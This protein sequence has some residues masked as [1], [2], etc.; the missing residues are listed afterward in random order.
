[1]SGESTGLILIPVALAAAPVLAAGLVVA[2]AAALTKSA[3]NAGVRY[4]QEKAQIRRQIRETGLSDGIASSFNEVRNCTER[5]RSA[6]LEA[7]RA[8]LKEFEFQR[9]QLLKAGAD[10]ELFDRFSADLKGQAQ[11]TLKKVDEIQRRFY[12]Q[13]RSEIELSM[14]S[15]AAIVNDQYVKS[16]GQLQRLQQNTSHLEQYAGQIAASAIR[17]GEALIGLLRADYDGER[18]VPAQLAGLEAQLAAVR[19][20]YQGRQYEAAISAAKDLTLNTYESIFD[21]SLKRSEWEN[22]YKNAYVLS[23]EVKA[24]V[25]TQSVITRQVK[26][27]AEISAGQALPDGLIGLNVADYC[28]KREDGQSEFAAYAAEAEQIWAALHG[29]S[30]RELDKSQLEQMILRLNTVLYPGITRCVRQGL[31]NMTNAF[32]RAE[33]GEQV[34]DFFEDHNF[35]FVGHSYDELDDSPLHIAFE[36]GI[37]DEL[38][39]VTLAPE[40]VNGSVQ[41]RVLLEQLQGDAMDEERKEFFREGISSMVRG[42]TPGA[43]VSLRCN[44]ATKFRL[45]NDTRAIRKIQQ[46]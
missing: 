28:L 43:D 14:Q 15:L 21:A 19:R 5:Q 32:L 7:S 30:A 34:I 25:E 1:M 3:I 9:S 11:N 8:M 29:E 36:N 33:L 12:S 38:L 10:T 16:V 13:Y 27:A 41:T 2:G 46:N 6:S 35:S 45:S 17:D 31:S 37:T 18:F 23:E 20:L 22:C 26:E 40:L 4:E 42:S 39:T 24:Y 44:E